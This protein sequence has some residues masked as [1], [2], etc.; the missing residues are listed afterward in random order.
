LIKSGETI[1]THYCKINQIQQFLFWKTQYHGEDTYRAKKIN[2]D[3]VLIKENLFVA[4][5]PLP[6][7]EGPVQTLF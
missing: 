2:L 7:I 3:E 4:I 1:R 6:Q 5:V